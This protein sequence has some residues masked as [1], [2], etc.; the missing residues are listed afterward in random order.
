MNVIESCQLPISELNEDEK[1]HYSTVLN[2][3]NKVRIQQIAD[4]EAAKRN[5]QNIIGG[6]TKILGDYDDKNMLKKMENVLKQKN[7]I[8]RKLHPYKELL[9]SNKEVDEKM[10]DLLH[11]TSQARLVIYGVIEKDLENAERQ[12]QCKICKKFLAAGAMISHTESEHSKFTKGVPPKGPFRC[13]F[14]GKCFFKPKKLAGHVEIPH[15]MAEHKKTGCAPL[16]D[17]D[18]IGP[19]ETS[20]YKKKASKIGHVE[21]SFD[22]KKAS[23]KPLLCCYCPKKFYVK[24]NYHKHINQVKCFEKMV[25]DDNVQYSVKLR[26]NCQKVLNLLKDE[27]CKLDFSNLSDFKAHLKKH[28]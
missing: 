25:R 5:N 19:V 24:G 26:Y 13:S 27:Q 16:Q 7:S 20:F 21:T 22:K 11:G 28:H 12:I 3:E 8:K 2:D 14:C 4:F 1:A 18:K 10:K 17:V 23:A 6:V 15:Q 9:K